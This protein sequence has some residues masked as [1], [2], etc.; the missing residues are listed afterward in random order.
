[1]NFILENPPSGVSLPNEEGKL[2]ISLLL[3][4]PTCDRDDLKY[5]DVVYSLIRENPE[6][7]VSILSPLLLAEGN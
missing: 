5:I 2:P 7:S 4:N 1:M 6:D 3:S